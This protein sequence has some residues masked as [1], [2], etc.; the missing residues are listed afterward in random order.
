MQSYLD[1]EC[2]FSFHF[3]KSVKRCHQN[4]PKGSNHVITL[5]PQGM[6]LL[7]TARKERTEREWGLNRATDC[8][9]HINIKMC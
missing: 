1:A 6:T 8:H 4:L 7:Q 9:Y 5:L 2:A 3:E